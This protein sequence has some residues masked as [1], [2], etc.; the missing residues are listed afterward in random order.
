MDAC[1]Q[2]EDTSQIISP[3]MIIFK[4]LVEENLKQMIALVGDPGRLRP[5]CKTH[6][7]REVIEL[8]LSLGI[9]KHKSATFAEAEMLAETGVKDI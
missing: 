6:K 5:H 2:I 8:E 7:M 4:D 1:Y 3:G 9:Q